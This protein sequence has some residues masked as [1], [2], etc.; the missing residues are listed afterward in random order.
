MMQIEQQLTLPAAVLD[1][2]PSTNQMLALVDGL[3]SSAL[4]GKQLEIV[5]V[6]QK[7]LTRLV[8]KNNDHF[9]VTIQ[10]CK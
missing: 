1:Q 6:L 7:G 3:F 10:L 4:S 5:S 9:N 2:L 8:R